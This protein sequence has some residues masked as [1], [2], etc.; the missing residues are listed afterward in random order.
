MRAVPL[1]RWA[2]RRLALRAVPLRWWTLRG[3][4]R[5]RAVPRSRLLRT[6][7][8]RSRVRALRRRTLVPGLRPQRAL[9]A[10]R[11]RRL[12]AHGDLSSQLWSGDGNGVS[13]TDAPR[14][15]MVPGSYDI[16]MM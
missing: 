9:R 12:I 7:G 15:A 16:G 10:G 5:W 1:W 6:H 11:V 14:A 2:L 4:A 13:A 3:N 8:R